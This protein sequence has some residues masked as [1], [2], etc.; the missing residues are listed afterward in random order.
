MADTEATAT[1][2]AAAALI[3]SALTGAFTLWGIRWTNKAQ[4]HDLATRLE[5][6]RATAREGLEQDRRQ[7]AYKALLTHVNLLQYS[8]KLNLQ[9]VT[10]EIRAV[11]KVREVD[12]ALNAGSAAEAA[13]LAS[14][15]PT[16]EE[17]RDLLGGP[18]LSER[19]ETLAVVDLLASD[20]VKSRFDAFLKTEKTLSDQIVRARIILRRPVKQQ[21][22][23]LDHAQASPKYKIDQAAAEAKALLEQTLQMVENT[24]DLG[25]AGDAI[26]KGT[27]EFIQAFETLEKMVRSELRLP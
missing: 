22:A 2:A 19:A 13:A 4:T 24:G 12:S 25:A 1:I 15:G 8:M 26:A 27:D 17:K 14:A 23:V 10:R 11:V 5:N 6:E 21:Q 18:T 20:E 3:G 16:E 7:L 9:V